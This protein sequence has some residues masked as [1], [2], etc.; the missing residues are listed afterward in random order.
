ME[1]NDSLQIERRG[2]SLNKASNSETSSFSTASG[3][4]E[5]YRVSQGK[6]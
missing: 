5:Q 6:K 3:K 4:W 2:K 1:E